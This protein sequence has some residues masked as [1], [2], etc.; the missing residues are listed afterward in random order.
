MTQQLLR[1]SFFFLLGF[2]LL[3]ILGCKKPSKKNESKITSG[4]QIVALLD[5]YINGDEKAEAK[6]KDPFDFNILDAKNYRKVEIDSL[7][8]DEKS[9]YSVLLQHKMPEYNKFLIYN[10]T[11]GLILHDK[12]V[13]GSLNYKKLQVN[14]KKFFT[15]VQKYS[16]KNILNV[17]SVKIYDIKQERATLALSLFTEVSSPSFLAKMNIL[18]AIEQPLSLSFIIYGD[19]S[20]FIPVKLSYDEETGFSS[21]VDNWQEKITKYLNSFETKEKIKDIEEELPKYYNTKL[22]LLRM[23]LPDKWEI[24]NGVEITS[25]FEKKVNGVLITREKKDIQIF[26]FNLTQKSPIRKFIKDIDFKLLSGEFNYSLFQSKLL[27]IENDVIHY[28]LA[29]CENEESL[30]AIKCKS[31]FYKNNYALIYYIMNSVNLNCYQ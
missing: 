1:N 12:N 15:I 9:Y 18:S 27:T 4:K 23:Y 30:V 25:L 19:K 21:K 28:I 29:K 10:D 2:L 17:E 6:L 31:E 3:G 20:T 13:A 22:D 24:K 7:V 8:I 14:S 16:V 26:V 11:L 5:A